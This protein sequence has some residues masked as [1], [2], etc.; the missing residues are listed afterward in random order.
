MRCLLNGWTVGRALRLIVGLAALVPAILQKDPVYGLLAVFLLGTAAA[1][2]GCGGAGCSVH[3]K[4]WVR[5]RSIMK[6]WIQK[7]RLYLIGGLLGALAGFLYWKYVGCVTG[8]CAI[9]SNP[10]KSTIYF[11]L[12]GALLFGLFK[13]ERNL[14]QE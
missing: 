5:R 8:T 14:N 1:N 7:N 11:T 13:R 10:I 3:S 6:N 12:T 2:I 9:T 4:K